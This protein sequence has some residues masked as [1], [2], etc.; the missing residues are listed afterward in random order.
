VFDGETCV[1]YDELGKSSGFISEGGIE[2]PFTC[3]VAGG[4]VI[5]AK[6]QSAP[7]FSTRS[8]RNI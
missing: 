4:S 3:P 8:T 1:R 6:L 2:I 7:E 5:S